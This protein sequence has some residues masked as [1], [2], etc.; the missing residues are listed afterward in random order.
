MA[1]FLDLS[2]LKYFTPLFV[3]LFLFILLYAILEKT[4]ILGEKASALNLML[5]ISLSAIGIFYTK[6]STLIE[7]IAP[8]MIFVFVFLF[9]L[10]M[11]LMFLGVQQEAIWKNLS[12]WTVL[13]VSFVIILIAIS[14]TYG[15]VFS[16]YSNT[17]S[18]KTI[19]GE[20][21]STIFNPRV[22]GSIFLLIIIAL[23][24]RLLAGKIEGK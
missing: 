24:I 6:L 3:W 13:I 22:L 11:G 19:S 7:F 15:D 1:T 5:A 17:T 23:S 12:V 18:G 20:A 2:L 9:I 16:P 4:K 14:Q 21:Q 8:W 10:F